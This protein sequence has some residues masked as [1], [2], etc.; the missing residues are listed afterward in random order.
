MSVVRARI[1]RALVSP[2]K[3]RVFVYIAA[4]RPKPSRYTDVV[5]PWSASRDH[6]RFCI[7]GVA[8]E[9]LVGFAGKGGTPEDPADHLVMI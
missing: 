8:A 9:A 6:C 4:L 1:C 7:A 3:A 2:C 5:E